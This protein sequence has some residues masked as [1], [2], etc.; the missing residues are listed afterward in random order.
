L[1]VDA[2]GL[3]TGSRGVKIEEQRPD[4][5]ILDD[6]DELHDSFATTQKKIET[7]TK[8]VLPAG[9]GD[10]AV[11][12]IQNKIHPE[13]IAARLSD[14]RADFLLDRQLSGPFSAID[15]LVYE[16]R[17]GRF[18]IVSGEATW[19]G[20]SLE[21]CQ[22]QINTWGLSAFLQ[23]AQHE[24]EHTGGIWDHIEFQHIEWD[25][26]PAFTDISVWVDPA[27][28]STDQSDCQ[29]ISAGGV[30]LDKKL[31]GLYFWEGILSPEA[32]L[33]R[34]I[35]KGYELG[36]SRVGV[37]TDQG[38]DTWQSVYHLACDK[39]IKEITKNW[40]QHNQ[41]KEIEEM[42]EIR[43]P[44]FASDKAGAGYGSKVERNARMLTSY[45]HGNVFH[46]IGTQSVIE[47][48]LR[49]FPNKPLDLA[50]SWYWVWQD[51][52]GTPSQIFI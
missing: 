31:Y 33:E 5:I 22:Q 38:G 35:R 32:A 7:I 13:S 34:A 20:Q 49:R 29:G 36:A 42:P 3:D 23:E 46:A 43:L 40:Q 41:G 17:D 16:Q 28:T 2:L 47:K 48:S 19:G 44:G 10:C 15:N 21:V 18:Y 26:L 1:T 51:L 30:T 4:L 37:E 39:I 12:F 52:L 45:E 6:V 50:D 11:L 25:K 24:V 9:S 8:S 14:G 27:V